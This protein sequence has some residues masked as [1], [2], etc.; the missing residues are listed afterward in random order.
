MVALGIC[1]VEVQVCLGGA[2]TR[3]SMTA[4][5]IPEATVEH[6]T[7]SRSMTAAEA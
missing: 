3:K 4:S 7:R 1:L 6:C 5:F 2:R